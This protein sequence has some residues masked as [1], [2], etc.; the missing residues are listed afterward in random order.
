MRLFYA[1]KAC[2][3]NVARRLVDI[4]TE[5]DE[6]EHQSAVFREEEGKWIREAA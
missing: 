3:H 5:F 2:G 4:L 6:I 1:L